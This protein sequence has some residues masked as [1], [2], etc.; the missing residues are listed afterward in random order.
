MLVI[1]VTAWFIIMYAFFFRDATR[2]LPPPN[3][4]GVGLGS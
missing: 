1:A 2:V 3:G 4:V